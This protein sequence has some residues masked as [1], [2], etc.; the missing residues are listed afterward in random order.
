MAAPAGVGV[1]AAVLIERHV[2]EIDLCA[3]RQL[4]DLSR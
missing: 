1:D 3:H 4:P 2:V